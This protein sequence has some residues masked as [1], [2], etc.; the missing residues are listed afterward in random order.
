MD[1]ASPPSPTV[2]GYRWQEV[3]LAG[4]RRTR[5]I[6][7]GGTGT[8]LVLVHG[9]SASIEQWQAVLPGLA[10]GR[11]VI[12]YDLAGFGW[13]EKPDVEYRYPMFAEQLRDVLDLLDLRRVDLLGSSLGATLIVRFEAL[14]PGRLRRAVLTNPGGFGRYVHPFLRV[15]T[16]PLLG[17]VVSRPTRIG[18][19]FA[20]RLALARR[21]LATAEAIGAADAL[22]R[23]PGTHRAT[24]RTL[25][26]VASPLGVKER[27]TFEE[28][29]A[30]MSHPT[31]VVWG[32]QDRLFPVSQME[33]ARALRPDARYE[34]IDRCGHFPQLDQPERLVELTR[35]HLG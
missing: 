7:T 26:G 3:E 21:E 19:A 35:G 9:L 30:A 18:S 23:L 27:D 8:P 2:A 6:D 13:A 5:L 11:R 15:P 4:G 16:L 29:W 14:H 1:P 28:Q 17:G 12:A 22:S 32:R 31:L 24:V 25:R 34:V 20:V 10:E 33:R